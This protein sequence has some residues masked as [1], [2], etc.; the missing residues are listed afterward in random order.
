M[1]AADMMWVITASTVGMGIGAMGLGTR[2]QDWAQEGGHAGL[3]L[4]RR[5][6]A[7]SSACDIPGP[8]RLAAVPDWPGN[9]RYYPSLPALAAEYSPHKHRGTLM[10]VVLL[11]LH[12]GALLGGLGMA[13]PRRVARRLPHRRYSADA[14]SAGLRGPASRVTGLLAASGKPDANAEARRLE[15][16]TGR[17]L[18][19][20]TVLRT[21]A[22]SK[23]AQRGSV[24]SLLSLE[25][26]RTTIGIWAIYLLNWIAWF[27]YCCGCPPLWRPWH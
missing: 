26:R 27:S 1:Q 7:D 25:Y 2:R 5:L 22:S 3:G 14:A 24:K 9:G 8:D 6:L 11:G 12:G 18:P 19:E 16:M 4:L 20:D 21:E 10:T 13:I 15:R 17:T 23:S